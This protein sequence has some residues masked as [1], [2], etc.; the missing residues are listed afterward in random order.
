MRAVDFHFRTV[1]GMTRQGTP[2]FQQ[3]NSLECGLADSPTRCLATT[4]RTAVCVLE[5]N[6]ENRCPPHHALDKGTLEFCVQDWGTTRQ[7]TSD[8]QQFNSL[9]CGLADEIPGDRGG[10]VRGM[11]EG[12]SENR[13]PRSTVN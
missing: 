4:G 5:G 12:N 8:F 6:S 2:D 1:G 11:G 9:N 10:E 7:A 13:C 3:F